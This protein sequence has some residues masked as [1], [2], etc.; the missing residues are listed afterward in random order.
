MKFYALFFAT[1]TTQ[2]LFAQQ[3]IEFRVSTI[4]SNIGDMDFWDQSDARWEYELLDNSVNI[5]GDAYE[6]HNQNCPA[7]ANINNVFA[8]NQ[9]SCQL[10]STFTFR[11]RAYENDG[12]FGK[13]ALADW[14]NETFST[15]GLTATTFTTIATYQATANGTNCSGGINVIYKITLQYRVTGSFLTNT[16]PTA[17]TASSLLVLAGDQ[18]TLTQ[19][20][21]TTTNGNAKFIWT[22]GD[23]NGPQIGTGNSIQV[24]VNTPTTYYVKSAGVCQ[25]NCAAVSIGTS[26]LAVSLSEFASSCEDDALRL[27]WT[28][29]SEMDND[30]FIVEKMTGI[31]KWE[32][33]TKVKGHGT[34]STPNYYQTDLDILRHNQA[35]FRLT[36]VD[37]DGKKTVHNPRYVACDEHQSELILTPN[38]S[39]GVF[40]VQSEYKDFE[41][42]SIQHISGLTVHFTQQGNRLEIIEPKSGIYFLVYTEKGKVYTKRFVII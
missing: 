35:Y 29:L 18:V 37:Y 17:I 9:Y 21:G 38:P 30:Y 42:I 7:P 10:P 19:Q 14:R 27:K 16:A 11:W 6:L 25:T 23:C 40:T 39:N 13:D 34:T 41:V 33:I 20:G 8:T 31:D 36:Q 4:E 26:G 15:A 28:T 22:S 24:Q 1:L 5:G 2:L 32:T 12:F 3:T